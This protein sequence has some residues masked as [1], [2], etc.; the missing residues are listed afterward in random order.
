MVKKLMIELGQNLLRRERLTRR[1]GQGRKKVSVRRS[2]P[3]E[4]WRSLARAA[5]AL[6][7]SSIPSQEHFPSR[8]SPALE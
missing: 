8:P 6:L 4:R 5:R 1:E 3:R 7:G 2:V